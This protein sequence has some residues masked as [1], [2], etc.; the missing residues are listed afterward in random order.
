[1]LALSVLIW[2]LVPFA[3]AQDFDQSLD[4]LV[5]KRVITSQERELLRGGG[6]A[7][8]MDRRRFEEVCYGCA[9]SR[10]DCVF[11]VAR[12]PPGTLASDSVRLIPSPKSFRVPVSAL[13]ARDGGTFRMDHLCGHAA[14]A[15]QS[16]KRRQSTALPGSWRRLQ[17]QW[18]WLT[19]ASDSGQLA[20]ACRSGLGST[21][22]HAGGGCSFGAGLE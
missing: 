3:P 19:S 5:R 20:D 8:P 10:Q 14:S 9:L 15:A 13:L 21:R 6:S 4:A 12:R 7:V 2:M 17:E 18:V 11:W 22:G 16:W 1:M